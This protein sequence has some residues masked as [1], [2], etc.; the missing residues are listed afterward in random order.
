MDSIATSYMEK[1][2]SQVEDAMLAVQRFCHRQAAGGGERVCVSVCERERERNRGKAEKVIA[3][4]EKVVLHR[5]VNKK[6]DTAL[7]MKRKGL[8][9]LINEEE[10]SVNWQGSHGWKDWS[11]P[12][13][14]KLRTKCSRLWRANMAHLRQSRPD[15]GL[16]LQVKFNKNVV[17]VLPPSF[18]SGWEESK[19]KAKSRR[20][21]VENTRSQ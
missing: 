14:C 12:A 16:G 10:G 19:R 13:T 4:A 3:F 5:V 6:K 11:T 20:V 15:F 7:C 18:A 9:G 2:G 21:F 17:E 8:P 1:R